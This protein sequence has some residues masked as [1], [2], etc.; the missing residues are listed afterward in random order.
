MRKLSL[1]DINDSTED[2]EIKNRTFSFMAGVGF[3]IG[4]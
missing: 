1:V 3:P 4:P 2:D